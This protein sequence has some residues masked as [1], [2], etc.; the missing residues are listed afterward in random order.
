[1]ARATPQPRIALACCRLSSTTVVND[2]EREPNC[3]TDT[4]ERSSVSSS[5]SSACDAHGSTLAMLGRSHGGHMEVTWRSHGGH[6]CVIIASRTSRETPPTV[7]AAIAWSYHSTA[8]TSH[9]TPRSASYAAGVRAPKLSAGSGS[10]ARAGGRSLHVPLSSLS[11]SKPYSSTPTAC[12]GR[13][14]AAPPPSSPS[15]A[16]A[17]PS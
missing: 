4:S 14:G 6:T 11:G 13:G 2:V 12:A 15:A 7:A 10:G 16:H 8:G 17:P 5:M 9:H 1:M 3:W